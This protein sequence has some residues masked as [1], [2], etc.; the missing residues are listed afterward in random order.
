[1][2]FYWIKGCLLEKKR[3]GLT[4]TFSVQLLLAN[5]RVYFSL[6]K[7]TASSIVEYFTIYDFFLK[8]SSRLEKYCQTQ[9]FCV[10][11]TFLLSI[12]DLDK[13]AAA[14]KLLR[15][16]AHQY[17]L[18]AR[19]F[20]CYCQCL[21]L[22]NLITFT[23]L[24][25]A[26]LLALGLYPQFAYDANNHPISKSYYYKITPYKP[27]QLTAILV[28]EAKYAEER[29]EVISGAYLQLMSLAPLTSFKVFT[30]Y[31]KVLN[32]QLK[33]FLGVRP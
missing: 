21:S 10:R 30:L 19:V 23:M 6:L 4:N 20:K 24:K 1:M 31:L 29:G 32:I 8:T 5:G 12:D 16:S 15:N 33:T 28:R 13:I 22:P 11:E 18:N 14:T 2:L 9:K 26:L 17:G 3:K 27:P 25:A 7:A